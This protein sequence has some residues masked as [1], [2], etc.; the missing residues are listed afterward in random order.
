M[1]SQPLTLGEVLKHLTVEGTLYEKLPDNVVRC[2]A[3]AH[4]CLIR[5]GREGICRVR[6]NQG[7][8][9]YV[10]HG[11]VAA[12]QV[13]PTEKKPF[14]HILPGSN[15]LT[16]GML[17]CDLHCGYCFVGETPVMTNHGPAA[18]ADLFGRAQRVEHMPD[19]DIAYPI[20]YRTVTASGSLQAIRA[21]F[22]HRYSGKMFV[23]KPYYLPALRCTPD[24]RL[25]ATD[26]STHMPEL[27]SAQQLT[28]RHYLAIPRKHG[29]ST[30]Q[31]I[32]VEKALEQYRTT[33]HVTWDLTQQERS[34]IAAATAQGRTS[35]EIGL[36]VGKSGSYIRHVRRK[37]GQ[38]RGASTRTS[39]PLIANGTI[40]FPHER[41]PGL[42]LAIDLDVDVARL[43]GYYC[44]EGSIVTNKK[45]PNSHVL[46]FSFAPVEVDQVEEVRRLLRDRLGLE[47]AVLRRST[48]LTVTVNKAS[49]S[50]L[51]KAL[52]GQRAAGK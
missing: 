14:F 39:G 16:F 44:A 41:Q 10:P 22:R 12:L 52:A 7:G 29:F 17:G 5:E 6:F 18:L 13:D 11:Y 27:I 19:A 37:L 8:K 2:Y 26:D 51:F 34:Y 31:V 50:L 20:G 32:D 40:R 36:V 1:A 35:R 47:S 48:T 38:G 9:L 28:Q 25:Y 49:V 23:I 33:Y 3:C 45:R 4:R 42:P 21:V 15:T 24:H 46:N 43:L 30:P